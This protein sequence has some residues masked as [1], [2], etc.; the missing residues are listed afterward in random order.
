MPCLLWRV[1]RPPLIITFRRF[2]FRLLIPLQR[3]ALGRIP[4]IDKPTVLKADFPHDDLMFKAVHVDFRDQEKIAAQIGRRSPRA[5][6]GRP[7]AVI[8]LL[9]G[10]NLARR[11]YN[12]KSGLG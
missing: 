3:Y 6:A 4:L 9:P 12:D 11:L 2:G 7:S 5:R 10:N 8:E 1:I